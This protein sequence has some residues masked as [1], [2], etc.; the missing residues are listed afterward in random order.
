M[1]KKI[2]LRKGKDESLRRFHPWVF[3]GAI[4]Q[5][6]DGVQ[7]GQL[8]RVVT[9]EGDFI[10][11]EH[12]TMLMPDVFVGCKKLTSVTVPKHIDY[13]NDHVFDGCKAISISNTPYGKKYSLTW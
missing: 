9:Y 10:V 2:Q 12:V 5:I 7:E 3:S 8:V 6:E 11:P 13:V 1:Y 4:Q